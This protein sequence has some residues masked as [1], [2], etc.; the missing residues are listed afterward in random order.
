MMTPAALYT[1]LSA[2]A[3]LVALVEDRIFAGGFAG[4]DPVAPYIIW[5]RIG[6]RPHTTHNESTQEETY[7]IQFACFG[8]TFEQADEVAQALKAALDNVE[9]STGDVG[10]YQNTRDGGKDPVLEHWRVDIDFLV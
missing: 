1:L 7:L 3:P 6:T 10:I 5:N 9:L 2:D 8:N 4:Q